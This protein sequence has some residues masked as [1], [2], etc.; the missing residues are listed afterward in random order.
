MVQYDMVLVVV[1]GWISIL[2]IWCGKELYGSLESKSGICY[3][4]GFCGHV[5]SWWKPSISLAV[6]KKSLTLYSVLHLSSSFAI[7]AVIRPLARLADQR[8]VFFLLCVYI[9]QSEFSSFQ[10][11]WQ[12]ASVL[13]RSFSFYSSFHK[14]PQGSSHFVLR[15]NETVFRCLRSILPYR[16]LGLAL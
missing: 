1:Y 6:K 15:Q 5:T 8:F 4:R 7:L 14:V 13:D 9:H 3:L 10:N 2:F 16:C 12:L 11:C